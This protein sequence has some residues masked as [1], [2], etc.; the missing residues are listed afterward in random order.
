MATDEGLTERV[1]EIVGDRR[2][3]KEKRMFGGL[4]FLHNGYM[5]CGIVGDS[6]MART[7]PEAYATALKTKHV[8]VM[9]FTGKPM[10]GYVFVDAK[11]FEDDKQLAYWIELGLAFVKSLPPK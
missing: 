11:G 1:R 6:L 10:K 9:D 5:F 8:R 7:G 2:G 3:V 4:A